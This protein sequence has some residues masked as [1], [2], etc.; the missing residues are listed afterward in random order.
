MHTST[1]S[2]SEILQMLMKD[3]KI[4][5]TVLGMHE[6]R[7]VVESRLL[8]QL[9]SHVSSPVGVKGKEKIGTATL[10]NF[11]G[12]IIALTC[13]HVTGEDHGAVVSFFEK[14]HDTNKFKLKSSESR[15]FGYSFSNQSHD[16]AGVLPLPNYAL[17]INL[18]DEIESTVKLIK[19]WTDE[20]AM[21]DK[22]KFLMITDEYNVMDIAP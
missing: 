18:I 11:K 7:L 1:V 22:I 15:K 2:D 9:L 4:L 3:N 16:V 19:W 10:V 13:S 17:T 5:E 12:V 6:S 20:E 21:V 14:D 8:F